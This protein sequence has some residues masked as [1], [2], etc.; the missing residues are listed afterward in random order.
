MARVNLAPFANVV[1]ALGDSR[2]LLAQALP[3]L[4][5][6]LFW[7]DAHWCGGHTAG[8]LDAE[9]PLLEELELLAPELDRHFVLI[10]D[11]RLFAMP[12]PLPHSAAAWP[13]LAA[14]FDVLRSRHEP[15]ITVYRDVII[16]VPAHAKPGLVAYL[17]GSLPKTGTVAT[18][19]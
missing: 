1:L 15:Y 5:P 17:Q 6:T 2:T 11:A 18:G 4:P 16:V 19:A 10:D 9:C 7:L 14:I 13:D 3:G 12:P 8:E